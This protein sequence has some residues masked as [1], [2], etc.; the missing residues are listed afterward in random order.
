MQQADQNRLT[1]WK[2]VLRYLKANESV[3]KDN[4]PFARA[5]AELE[6]VIIKATGA[7]Q[8]QTAITTGISDD[9]EA[10]EAVAI[11]KVVAIAKSAYAYALEKGDHTFET[12]VS[13]SK[14]T[15]MHLPGPEQLE[16]L[17]SIVAAAQ[18]K[19]EELADYGVKKDTAYTD[20]M[21]AIRKY[22]EAPVARSVI[23]DK[24]VVTSGIPGIMKEG[25]NVLTRMDNL[26]HIFNE[27]ASKFAAGYKAVRLVVDAGTRSSDNTPAAGNA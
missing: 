21:E 18:E 12:A 26:V 7:I 14:S 16:R 19:D 4:K 5:V 6:A 9:R 27:T 20:A 8:G 17:R 1:M 25:R 2:T 22:E 15:L 23:A 3:W 13:F 10:L 24:S 11:D